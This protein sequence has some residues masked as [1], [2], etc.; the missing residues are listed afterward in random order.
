M[1]K[2]VNARSTVSSVVRQKVQKKVVSSLNRLRRLGMVWF[3]GHGS[4]K[5]RITESV[6]RFG[7]DIRAKAEDRFGN[8]EFAAAVAHKPYHAQTTQA[9]QRRNHLF[10]HLLTN[11]A[12]NRRAG[13]HPL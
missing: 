13:I 2:R 12:R 7:A 1:L 9:V 8:A 11:N 10:L 5:F 4:S 6:F 3:M